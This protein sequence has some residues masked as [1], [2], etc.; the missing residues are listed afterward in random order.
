MSQIPDLTELTSK[1]LEFIEYYDNPDTQELIKNNKGNYNYVI[2]QKF[3]IIPYAM[4]KL[5]SDV[6]NRAQNLQKIMEMIKMLENVK[7]G[8]S[9]LQSAEEEFS[10]KRAKEYLY[11][12][13]GGRDNFYKIAEESKLKRDKEKKKK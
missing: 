7:N 10:E 2:S 3:E 5:L 12:Q 8:T 1:I 6:D 11:P 13:F 4:I 9:T